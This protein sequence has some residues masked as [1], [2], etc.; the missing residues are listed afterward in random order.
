MTRFLSLIVLLLTANRL[1]AADLLELYREALSQD[2]QFVAAQTQYLAGQEVVPQARANL[3]PL[4]N[5]SG[6]INRNDSDVRLRGA[7]VLRGGQA[8]FSTDNV[9]LAVTQPLFRW[10]SVLQLRQAEV[11]LTQNEAQLQTALQ[12]LILRVAQAYFDVL[13]AQDTLAFV[14]AQKS[15]ISEQLAQAKRNFEVGTATIVDTHEAQSRFDVATSQEIAAENELEIR[16]RT[17]QQIIGRLPE[18]LAPLSDEFK[19]TPPI[20]NDMDEWVTVSQRQAYPVII[21]QAALDIANKEIERQR[22]GHYPTLDA[23]ASIAESSASGSATF[24]SGNDITDKVIGLQLALPIYQGG[25]VNSRVREALANR[26]RAR[27]QLEDAQRTAAL[28]TRQA[29]LN[30][31]NGIAEVEALRAALA[32]SQLSLD[33]TNTGL[34]VGVR[35]QIDVLNAQQQVFNAK[36]A[37]ALVRYA[38]VLNVL[39]LEAAVG[40]LDESDV[41]AVN[42]S[43]TGN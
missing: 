36:R 31:T 26:D 8:E 40:T 17:L 39:R 30:V 18:N 28:A 43:L 24:G 15:A 5:L 41:S 34:E 1:P 20:P 33:S 25:L 27:S 37:L 35:T 12:N 13:G 10:Q 16:K 3:L 22:A 2:P 19:S 23:V 9:T 29:F 42:A 6:N 7:S 32:S 4:V 11:Q 38:T 21:Q 14:R